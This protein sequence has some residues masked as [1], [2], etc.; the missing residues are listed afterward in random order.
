[1]NDV[2]ALAR[3]EDRG[4]D[5]GDGDRRF[6]GRGLTPRAVTAREQWQRRKRRETRRRIRSAAFE[7]FETH[8]FSDVGVDQ[9]VRAAGVSRVTFFRHFSSKEDVV[10][11]PPDLLTVEDLVASVAPPPGGDLVTLALDLLEAHVRHVDDEAFGRLRSSVRLVART[12]S[13]RSALYA[14]SATWTGA[15]AR[16]LPA[17]ARGGAASSGRGAPGDPSGDGPSDL[18]VHVAA[19]L[20]IATLLEVLLWWGG[21]EEPGGRD[22]LL[23]MMTEARRLRGG[24]VLP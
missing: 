6:D 17:G 15:V 7:L 5:S 23:R 1:M 24:P 20:V 18:T 4:D 9:I 19:R 10:V 13:L 16:I 3:G 11:G 14:R 21:Q 12:P 22:D 2:N 8:G